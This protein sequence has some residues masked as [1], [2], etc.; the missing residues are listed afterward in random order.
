MS[1]SRELSATLADPAIADNPDKCSSFYAADATV[2]APGM[3]AIK[4]V[5]SMRNTMRFAHAKGTKLQLNTENAQIAGSGD[6]ADT[7]GTWQL[8]GAIVDGGFALDYRAG[9]TQA[10]PRGPHLVRVPCA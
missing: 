5:A 2:Y 7:T 10:S 4:G 6:I 3:P 9:R 1:I 8:T